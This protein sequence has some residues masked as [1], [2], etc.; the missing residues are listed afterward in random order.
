LL[1][2]EAEIVRTYRG[3]RGPGNCGERIKGRGVSS[4]TQTQPLAA[5]RSTISIPAAPWLPTKG[6]KV[7]RVRNGVTVRGKIQYAD[8]LQVLVKWDD[9]SSSS[10]RVDKGELRSVRRPSE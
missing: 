10:F 6:E 1:T 9:G 7:E 3:S 8:E 4:V 2:A 5:S